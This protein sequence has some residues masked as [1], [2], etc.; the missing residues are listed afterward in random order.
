MIR[1]N[2]TKT[3]TKFTQFFLC[4]WV[5]K[6]FIQNN[7]NLSEQVSPDSLIF[8]QICHFLPKVHKIC[9]NSH[10]I[11]QIFTEFAKFALNLSK[12][13]QIH[14][15]RDSESDNLFQILTCYWL[16]NIF[17]INILLGAFQVF[18][19]HLRGREGDSQMITVDHKGG[20]G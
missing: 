8:Y 3:F 11:C 18:C 16:D 1:Q 5:I 2:F 4:N 9:Q 14:H 7:E 19:D 12:F 17:T 10:Q 20:G 13:Q 6:W 15:Q